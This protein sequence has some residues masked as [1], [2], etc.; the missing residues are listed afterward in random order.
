MSRRRAKARPPTPHEA[1]LEEV[2][3]RVGRW[4][5]EYDLHV[6]P[7]GILTGRAG[8]DAIAAFA[9]DLLLEVSQP[10]CCRGAAAPKGARPGAEAA[11]ALLT[12]RRVPR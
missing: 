2:R 4:H 7:G 3:E 5:F 10:V 9:F 1:L 12:R 11:L 8:L 6:A